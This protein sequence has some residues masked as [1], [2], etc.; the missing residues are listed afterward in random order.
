M[1]IIFCLEK[2]SAEVIE[3]NKTMDETTTGV[4]SLTQE[5]HRRNIHQSSQIKPYSL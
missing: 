2:L 4:M 5:R 1:L 3:S